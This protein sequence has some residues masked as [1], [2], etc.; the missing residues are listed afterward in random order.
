MGSIEMSGMRMGLYFK[1]LL[2]V[3][4]GKSRVLWYNQ[5]CSSLVLGAACEI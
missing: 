5:Q 3:S 4:L 2:S 1:R